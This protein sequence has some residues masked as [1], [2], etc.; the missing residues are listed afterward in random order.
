MEHYR[1]KLKSH[2]RCS[3]FYTHLIGPANH[4]PLA[5][6]TSEIYRGCDLITFYY[7]LETFIGFLFLWFK[8][9]WV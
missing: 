8:Y 9:P 3:P 2:F 4:R 7:A 6:Q 1:L 5:A